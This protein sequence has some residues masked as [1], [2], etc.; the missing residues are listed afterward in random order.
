MLN[1]KTKYFRIYYSGLLIKKMKIFI[2][3]FL[4]GVSYR[5]NPSKKVNLKNYQP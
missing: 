1:I 5:C 3:Y 2:G 4:P